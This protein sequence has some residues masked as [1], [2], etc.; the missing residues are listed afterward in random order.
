MRTCLGLLA[1]V[2]MLSAC[3]GG[4]KHPTPVAGSPVDES[5]TQHLVYWAALDFY[6][7]EVPVTARDSYDLMTKER[8]AR[9]I[10]YLLDLMA[11]PTPLRADAVEDL[12][13]A[14]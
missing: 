8:D 2:L 4:Q 12:R 9:F 6:G 7:G 1:V 5:V 14:R 3:G 11:L 13:L 10:P